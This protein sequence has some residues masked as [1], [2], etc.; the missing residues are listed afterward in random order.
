METMII[1]VRLSSEKFVFDSKFLIDSIS[2][3]V[4]VFI[5]MKIIK[6]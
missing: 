4:S 2:I 6:A 1:L 3:D 5:I